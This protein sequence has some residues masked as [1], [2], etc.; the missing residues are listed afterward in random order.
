MRT[1]VKGINLLPK[2][3]IQAEQIKFIQLI[4]AGVMALEILAF[5][6][7]AI[8]SPKIEAQKVIERLD[9]VSAELTDSRFN[10]VN[11]KIQQLEDAKVAIK[12]WI[13]KYGNI[14]EENLISARLLDSIIA[15]I[16]IN[17]TVNQITVE[18][19]DKTVN[20]AGKDVITLKGNTMDAEQVVNYVTIIESVFGS[21]T[22]TY[23]ATYDE[24]LKGFEYEINITPVVE[25]K[26]VETENP[27]GTTEQ[28]ADETATPS[29]EQPA[30][31][32]TTPSTEQPERGAN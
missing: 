27:E 13:D 6:G 20:A 17:T 32:T 26:P 21:G 3:Y 31:E 23:K 1:Q 18:P 30:D 12:E 11:K 22:T 28:P 19:A 15:R 9:E 10:D 25:V 24:E 29:T 5:V 16:P 7:I 2:E 14:K 4:V 8:I